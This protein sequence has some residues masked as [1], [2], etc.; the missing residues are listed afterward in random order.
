MEQYNSLLI[1][2]DSLE[3]ASKQKNPLRRNKGNSVLE[4]KKLILRLRN[5]TLLKINWD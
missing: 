3:K 4:K 1:A 2:L 5:N